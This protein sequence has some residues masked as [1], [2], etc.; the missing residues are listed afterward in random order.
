M[1]IVIG[2]G[3]SGLAAA[4]ALLARGR[5]VTMLD[6]GK[7][8]SPDHQKRKAEFANTPARD[9]TEDQKA[10]WRAPQFSPSDNRAH[11]YGSNHAQ[12][13]LADHVSPVPDWLST[14]ASHAIGGLSNV[15][16]SAILPNRQADIEAWPITIEDLQPHYQAV[17][18]LLPV[19][20]RKD[21]LAALFPAISMN[22]AEPLKPGPQGRK[23]LA[24]L[25]RLNATF[26]TSGVYAGQARQAVR[27]DCQYCG[28]CLHGCPWDQVFSAAQEIAALQAHPNFTYRPGALVRG[29]EETGDGLLVHL[30]SGDTLTGARLY[31][32]AGILETARIVL[33]STG[34]PHP[35]RMKDSRHF[36]MP[37]LHTW[38]AEQDPETSAHHTLTEAFVEIDDP[39]VSP[40]LTH[41]QIYGWNAFYAREMVAN[42]GSRIP[43]S[44]PLFKW[45]SKR[46][47]VAQT[48]LHSDHCAEI[49]LALAP[50][51]DKLTAKLI[52]KDE[53]HG[54][55]KAA[56]NKLAA[57]MRKAGLYALKF[58][59]RLDAPGASFHSG[60][61][62]PMSD[63]PG[64]LETNAVGRLHGSERVHL[65]DASVLP[66]IPATTITL[67]VMANAHRIGALS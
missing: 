34:T 2:S 22:E 8:L 27:G 37:L 67:S 52:E 33:S 21:A 60:G 15:W 10:A 3:P 31:V 47:M 6:G 62:F 23:L 44:A 57:Q 26:E 20:G 41:T 14:K 38:S 61:T 53:A 65:I 59:S 30:R 35:V 28:M 51:G 7:T 39:S 66:S 40:Y 24:K 19:S 32:G 48:F 13:L 55:M 54:V 18:A 64:A 43:A 49:E 29:F 16:G 5:S 56:Q 1:D 50:D 9:W 12:E 45:L 25:D 58:A 36:F 11:R 46:L 4:T 42:Y 17:S 63:A